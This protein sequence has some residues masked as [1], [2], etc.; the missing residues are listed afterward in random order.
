MH[1]M[2]WIDNVILNNP[3]FKI[4]WSNWAQT[5]EFIKTQNEIFYKNPNLK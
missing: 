1:P 3:F 5:K 4:F 2:W